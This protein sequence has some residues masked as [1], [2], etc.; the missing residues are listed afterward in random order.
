MSKALYLEDEFRPRATIR[1]GGLMF[2]A[3]DAIALIQE[4]QR[5]RIRVLGI[6]SFR[7]TGKKTEL[8]MDDILD[9]STRAFFAEDDWDQSIKFIKDR[10]AQGFHFE[11]VLGDAI[12]IGRKAE[13]CTAPLPRA[14]SGHSEGA[15]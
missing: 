15:R 6:D 11:V 5:R 13:Q 9:L 8:M 1:S 4:A 10:E 12:E 14:P 3:D 2:A 7:L